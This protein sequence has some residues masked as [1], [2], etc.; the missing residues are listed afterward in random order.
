MEFL[1]VTS[2][3]IFLS[4]REEV[5]RLVNGSELSLERSSDTVEPTVMGT[6]CLINNSLND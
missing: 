4:S 6:G 3:A 5:S 1:D 2:R